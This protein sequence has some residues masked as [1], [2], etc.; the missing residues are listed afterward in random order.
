MTLDIRGTYV[1]IG[2]LDGITYSNTKFFEDYLDWGGVLIEAQPDNAKKLR[3]NRSS[4]KNNIISEAVCSEGQTYVNF[5]G[6]SAV[7]GVVEEMSERHKKHFF[8]GRKTKTIQVPCRPIGKML[9]DAGVV[10]VDFFV[11][12]VEGAELMVLETMDWSIPVKV[13]V[14]EMGRGEKDKQLI[15]L[16]RS[17]GYKKSLWNIRG[18][19]LMGHDCAN[20][21]VFEHQNY[22][23][24]F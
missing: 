3:V 20:N 16:L 1:E 7:G 12:D 6:S 23:Q 5:T 14:V 8:S 13:F 24:T 22:I 11:L 18:F 19:C 21:Q 10:S 15:E 2:A 17:K 4:A 9:K